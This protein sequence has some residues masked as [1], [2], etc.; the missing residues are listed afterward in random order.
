MSNRSSKD[1]AIPRYQQIA[2][3]IAARIASGEFKEGEKIYA[4]SAIAS[5]YAV[6]PETARRAICVLSDLDIVEAEKGSGIVIRSNKK[7]AEYIKQYQKRQTVDSI[8]E[9]VLKSI[10]RQKKEMEY[11]NECLKDLI[12]TSEHFRSM[13]PFMPY[14]IRITKDCRYLNK[15]VGDIRFWQY[16]GAT[17]LAVERDDTVLKSPGPY[18]ELS[19]ND[20]LYFLTQDESAE[21][22]KEFLYPK[23]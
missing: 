12:E 3:E 20:I 23:K 7:A 4:R 5:Q 22:V 18:I 6:S 15:S 21:R 1:A 16:T 19:E 13:N 14:E 10:N 11:M 8:K 17:I 2:V 9:N